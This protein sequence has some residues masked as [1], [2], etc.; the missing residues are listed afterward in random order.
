MI[1]HQSFIGKDRSLWLSNHSQLA[2]Y[3]YISKEPSQT[4][5]SAVKTWGSWG[6]FSHQ[7]IKNLVGY[8]FC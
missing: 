8:F 2:C 5:G 6:T 3:Y 7:T 4:S 1:E